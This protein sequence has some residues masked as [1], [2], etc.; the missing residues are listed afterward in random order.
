MSE[1]LKAIFNKKPEE[2]T[3]EEKELFKKAADVF[4]KAIEDVCH[5]HGMAYKAII[6]VTQDGV[7]PVLDI[8]RIVE[9]VGTEA[10]A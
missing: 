3:E 10:N 1:E 5:E 7:V 4:A 2:I 6:R 9:P 8:V